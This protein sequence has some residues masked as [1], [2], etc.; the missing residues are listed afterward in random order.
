MA[1]RKRWTKDELLICLNVYHKLT[2]GQLDARQPV[3][4]ALAEKLNRSSN[5]VAMKLSNFASLDPVL[6]IRRIKG[7]SGV[8]RLDRETWDEFHNNL[9]EFASSSEE[10]L[11]N[12]FEAPEH[13]EIQVIPGDGIRVKTRLTPSST[14]TKVVAT[15]RR[16]QS[17]FRE[18]V[19]NNY[20]G[21]CGV[22]GLSVR[23]LLVASHILPW[24][25]YPS[26]RLD[27]RNG[28]SLSRLHDT[29]FD[30]GLISFNDD[31]EMILSGRL[32]SF[33]PERTVSENFGA[34]E[35][36]R[37]RIPEEGLTPNQEFLRKHRDEVFQNS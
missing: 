16:G 22:T 21:R 4:I 32:R 3:I 29:A 24:A 14:E 2:F 19:I 20:D 18:V 34:Y 25:S 26:D 31:F 35:G 6:K 10:A 37:L 23:E 7:L 36:N 13:G 17:Y 8:S 5:S 15:Q 1:V 30:R 11:R 9:T 33:L 28:I 27:V 12:L